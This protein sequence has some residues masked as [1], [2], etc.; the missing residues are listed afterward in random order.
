MSIKNLFV[1]EILEKTS[2]KYNSDIRV[3]QFLNEYR[4]EMGG[5]TVRPND[6]WQEGLKHLLLFTTNRQLS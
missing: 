2:S 6:I 5:L 1:P 3:Y 4:L